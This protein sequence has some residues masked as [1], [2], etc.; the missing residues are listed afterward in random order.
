MLAQTNPSVIQKGNFYAILSVCTNLYA[1]A[2][3]LEFFST[4]F[5]VDVVTTL[6]GFKTHLEPGYVLGVQTDYDFMAVNLPIENGDHVTKLVEL[7]GD[8][9]TCNNKM[10][11]VKA[12]KDN[13]KWWLQVGSNPWILRLEVKHLSDTEITELKERLC[14]HLSQMGH[15]CFPHSDIRVRR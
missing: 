14:Q 4:A 2:Y 11:Y 12:N 8:K 5:F 15:M 3:L 7:A 9:V 13:L 6:A 1:V 10:E